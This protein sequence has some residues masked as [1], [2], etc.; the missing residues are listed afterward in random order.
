M[1]VNTGSNRA[2]ISA[3]P[4]RSMLIFSSRIFSLALNNRLL[5][6]SLLVRKAS[7]ISSM[8]KP[9]RFCV[10]AQKIFALFLCFR[11]LYASLFRKQYL[12]CFLIFFNY[13][14]FHFTAL[15]FKIIPVIFL[16]FFKYREHHF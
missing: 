13:Y 2:S 11:R 15:L 14:R 6:V 5:M 10:N 9:Q 4:G 1:V 8:P 3:E 7:A 12:I 16:L